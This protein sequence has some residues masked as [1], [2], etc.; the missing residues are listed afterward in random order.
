MLANLPG[1]YGVHVTSAADGK[2]IGVYLDKKTFKNGTTKSITTIKNRAYKSKFLTKTNKP[3]QHTI[4]HELGHA[5]WNSHLKSAK[6]VRAG[7]E[8][9]SMF[10]TF[11]KEKPKAYGRY[12]YSNVNEF[13]AEVTAKAVLGRAD[14]YTRF[15]KKT[16]KKH[17]L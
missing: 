17:K 11:K 4:I 9:K 3:V 14:K 12:A 8:I 15:L 16:I 5:T 13:W 7:T 2:S 10:K 6:A 1:A